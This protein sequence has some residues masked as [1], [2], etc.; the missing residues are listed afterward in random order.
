MAE[1]EYASREE[2]T[3]AFRSLRAL[4]GNKVSSVLPA[5]PD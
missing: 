2:Q 4:Q 1:R 3:A 5:G